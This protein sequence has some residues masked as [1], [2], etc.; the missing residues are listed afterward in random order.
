MDDVEFTCFALLENHETKAIYTTMAEAL[1]EVAERREKDRTKTYDVE[2]IDSG[3]EFLKRIKAFEGCEEEWYRHILAIAYMKAA[4]DQI[5]FE[6][7]DEN[8]S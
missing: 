4:L 7:K 2:R 8:K 1:D 3:R 5:D 6:D